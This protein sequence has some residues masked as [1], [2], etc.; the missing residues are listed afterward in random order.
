[1]ADYSIIDRRKNPSGKNLPNR[2]RFLK[3]VRKYLREQVREAMNTRKIKSKDGTDISVPGDGINEPSFDYDRSTGEW[4]RI[5]PGN[6]EFGVGDSISKPPKGGQGAGK[7]GSNSGGGITTAGTPHV[8]PLQPA[9]QT[10]VHEVE[11]WPPRLRLTLP[12]TEQNGKDSIILVTRRVKPSFVFHEAAVVS[13]RVTVLDALST[14]DSNHEK[15][16]FNV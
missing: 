15:T 3:R 16:C 12:G 14:F 9:A 7:E 2:Q 5:L 10:Q 11:F 1:M 4:E 8:C 13:T 6:K